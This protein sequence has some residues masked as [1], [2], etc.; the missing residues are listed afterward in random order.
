MRWFKKKEV[1]EELPNLAVDVASISPQLDEKQVKNRLE[2][3]H[4]SPP[5]KR[6]PTVP[7][8]ES[9]DKKK[10]I[11]ISDERGYFKEL[12]KNVVE[13]T[14]DLDKRDSWYKN[15]FLPGDIVFQ[16][17]EYWEKQQ[18]EILLKNVSGDLKIR[19]VEKTD[20]LH[21]LEKEWQEV[22][23]HLLTKEEAIRKEEKDLKDL[24]SEFINLFKNSAKRRKSE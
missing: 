19:L 16:M 22:Y 9:N 8:F 7:S 1:P 23:F 13:G 20:K 17:R 11:S 3:L 21:Q 4:E 5:I 18:S 14:N 2:I 12:I 6:L 10:T 15:K 24:L